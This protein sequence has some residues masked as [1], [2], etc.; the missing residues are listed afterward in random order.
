MILKPHKDHDRGPR[1]FPARSSKIGS[2]GTLFVLFCAY[3][4]LP[5]LEIPIINLSLS[6]PLFGL[7][8]LQL[9][10]K[11]GF[12]SSPGLGQV[13]GMAWLV[14]FGIV[15]AAFA[16]AFLSHGGRLEMSDVLAVVRYTYWILVYA[17]SA[18]FLARKPEVGIKVVGV[19]SA[20]IF[21]LAVIRWYEGIVFGKIGA[22]TEPKLMTQNSYAMLFSTYAPFLFVFVLDRKKRIYAF[23]ALLVVLSAV[24]INGSR[25]SWVAISVSLG[26]S[27]VLYIMAKPTELK[28]IVRVVL[29]TLALAAGAFAFWKVAPDSVR[30]S[31]EKRFSSMESLEMDKSY[32]ARKVLQK[33]ARIIFKEHPLTGC[34]PGRFS[35][36]HVYL[37]MP[38]V[39]RTVSQEKINTMNS[40]NSYMEFLSEMGLAGLIPMIALYLFLII[41]GFK[42]SLYFVRERQFWPLGIYVSLL[43]MSIHMW[44]ISAFTNTAT[45]LK[46]GMVAGIILAARRLHFEK[47]R[48]RMQ[49]QHKDPRP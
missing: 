15:T 16:N 22:W 43:S 4:A 41:K 33:K 32:Q 24:V 19:I 5:V 26:A 38:K 9:M 49:G 23:L 3:T 25:S 36:T 18:Y 12:R 17:F 29:I 20:A 2:M 14:F 35:R 27:G 21:I 47:M 11:V 31:F 13:L 48:I 46:F 6:A 45:W 37:E 30:T 8:V 40:H 7:L 1:D 42:A 28:V 44:A 10:F 39:L 34:G